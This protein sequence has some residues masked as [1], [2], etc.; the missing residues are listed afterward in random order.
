MLTRQEIEQGAYII[1]Q[2]LARRRRNGTPIPADLVRLHSAYLQ[3]VADP[4]RDTDE[5]VTVA[6]ELESTRERAAR[7]GVSE[8]TVRRRAAARGITKTSAGYIFG[9]T[10]T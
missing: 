3:A 1:G 7:L 8:R 5:P 6:T 10:G 2:E 4:G 9:R